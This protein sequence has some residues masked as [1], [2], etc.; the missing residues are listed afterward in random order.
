M[1][2]LIPVAVVG[3]LVCSVVMAA[4]PAFNGFVY[5]VD[6]MTVD[7]SLPDAQGAEL[8][9]SV[10]VVKTDTC[11]T[12]YTLSG[13]AQMDPWDK[14]YI[15][16]VDGGGADSSTSITAGVDTVLV[17]PQNP[18]RFDKKEWVTFSAC[19]LDSL[20]SQTDANDTVYVRVH[21]GGTSQF[22][23]VWLEDVFLK[24]EVLDKSA[25]GAF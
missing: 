12:L 25:A 2:R 3:V 6:T 8:I 22:D 5:K 17:Q 24:A 7:S 20:I 14:L 21:C 19:Y 16:F 9:D 11:Y 23:K 15:T 13:R 10:I 4:A 18:G 1:K